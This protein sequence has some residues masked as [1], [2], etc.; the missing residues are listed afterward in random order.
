MS[1]DVMAGSTAVWMAALT[2]DM[3]ADQK[4]ELTAAKSAEPLA[5]LTV[6]H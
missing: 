3:L 6:A 5:V 4:V 1:V 2:V